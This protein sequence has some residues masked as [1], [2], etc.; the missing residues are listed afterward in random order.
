MDF[1]DEVNET[2]PKEAPMCRDLV[3]LGEEN[4]QETVIEMV[5]EDHIE[6]RA[7]LLERDILTEV[8]D[9]LMVEDPLV[10][11]ILMKMGDPLEEEDTLMVMEDHLMEEDPL[12]LLVDKNHLALK[13]HWDQ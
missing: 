12:D 1:Q 10:E 13:D 5:L 2:P 8:G 7:P 11:D 9:P 6:I 3:Q 4:I